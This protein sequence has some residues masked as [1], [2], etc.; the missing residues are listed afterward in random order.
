MMQLATITFLLFSAGRK[1]KAPF[2]K[3][4]VK[5]MCVPPVF[6]QLFQPVLPLEW[7][8]ILKVST[9]QVPYD[10]GETC[11]KHKIYK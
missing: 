1:Q 8:F 9:P 3:Y 5:E 11:Y 7:Q 4:L 10:K 2:S 6:C